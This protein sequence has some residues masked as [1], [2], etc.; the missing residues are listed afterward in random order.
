[1]IL[2]INLL[3]HHYQGN[4]WHHA[5]CEGLVDWPP[6]PWRIL[7]ALVAGA[8]NVGL[9]PDHQPAL[10]QLLHKLAQYQP[11][12]R[13]PDAAYIQHRSPRPQVRP[14]AKIDPGKTLYSAGF[15]VNDGNPQ[16]QICYPFDLTQTE[17]LILRLILNGLTYLGRKESAAEWTL[18]ATAAA[19]ETGATEFTANAIPDASGTQLKLT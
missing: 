6:A 15:L 3:L 8:Y 17:D 18:T 13:L 2:T 12:Y 5:H 7:R 1:M 10:K 14:G 11:T 16:I 9:P 4:A 19:T